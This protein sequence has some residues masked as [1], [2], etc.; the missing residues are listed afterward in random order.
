MKPKPNATPVASY[1]NG[2]GGEFGVFKIADCVPMREIKPPSEKQLLARK[3]SAIKAKMRSNQAKASR[4]A[5]GWL[6]LD[7]YFIDTETTGLDACDQIIE[8]AIVDSA[9][10][11]HFESR[12]RPT[13][14]IDPGAID[15]HGISLEEL[16]SCPTWPEISGQV[17]AILSSR[18]VI[19]FNAEF[20][21]RLLRQT[22][23]AFSDPVA[24]I[25]T[26]TTH[27]AMYLSAEVYGPTNRY[28]TIS[29][30]SAVRESGAE[31]RGPSHSAIGDALATLDVVN[32]IANIDKRLQKELIDLENIPSRNEDQL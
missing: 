25:E 32:E 19:I 30:D 10:V 23:T 4:L 14:P 7:P 6:D 21:M 29:L 28:G 15:V 2:Y 17:Q 1:K 26:L 5:I 9:G 22:A 11:T 13:V 31:W 24:W 12:L 18:P 20:D 16:A 3:I 27:C 8:L